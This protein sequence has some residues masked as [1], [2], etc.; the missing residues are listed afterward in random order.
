MSAMS[1]MGSLGYSA[2]FDTV[3]RRMF[4]LYM[5][6][7]AR[8][9]TTT[10]TVSPEKATTFAALVRDRLIN[11]LSRML[12][13]NDVEEL[14]RR[15]VPMFE[16][17]VAADLIVVL[18]E[19]DWDRA[20][21]GV[22]WSMEMVSVAQVLY[23]VAL[24]AGAFSE[25]AMSIGVLVKELIS[26]LQAGIEAVVEDVERKQFEE[27]RKTAAL[28][29]LARDRDQSMMVSTKFKG[30]FTTWVRAR[31]NSVAAGYID[32]RASA[33]G[34][35]GSEEGEVEMEIEGEG[36][37]GSM[38]GAGRGDEGQAMGQA[39]AS[40]LEA[41]LMQRVTG[42]PGN[43]LDRL[44]ESMRWEVQV[45]LGN[46]KEKEA[47]TQSSLFSTLRGIVLGAQHEGLL[48]G[49][50]II[51]ADVLAYC[52]LCSTASY[53]IKSLY[54]SPAFELVEGG[55]KGVNPSNFNVHHLR[56]CVM[57]HLTRKSLSD[58]EEELLKALAAIGTK[59]L[60][61]ST[62]LPSF[63][64]LLNHVLDVSSSSSSSPPASPIPSTLPPSG[65][66][67][68]PPS[69]VAPSHPV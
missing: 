51:Q 58:D 4:M 50:T 19:R 59:S 54:F 27:A 65:S 32:A 66:S 18:A 15:V 68:L 28:E 63:F 22:G 45:R 46:R 2:L 12:G 17:K 20:A 49:L 29:N 31:I 52:P 38:G 40:E 35:P 30:M 43:S 56:A 13:S 21:A 33:R 42:A 48:D 47:S 67:S 69:P 26:G 61:S 25:G 8:T 11:T 64:A 53:A 14:L 57:S 39:L 34:V 9:E 55:G 10:S 60:S 3:Y 6:E 23:V 37:D 44:V 5:K 16:A 24:V 41:S 7:V 62:H 1:A 36:E